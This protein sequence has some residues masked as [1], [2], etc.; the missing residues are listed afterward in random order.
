MTQIADL[1]RKIFNF[2]FPAYGNLYYKKDLDGET[3]IP[4]MG[5]FVF[6]PVSARQFRHG[7]REKME[8][9]RGPCRFSPFSFPL[10]SWLSEK[11]RHELG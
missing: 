2:H 4:T 10:F 7:E 11:N 1:E 6:G 8:S 3:Q 9:G 5:D